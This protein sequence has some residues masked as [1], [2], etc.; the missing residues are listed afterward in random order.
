MNSATPEIDNEVELLIIKI[1]Q[2][3]LQFRRTITMDLLL[4]DVLIIPK[5]DIT[6]IYRANI[7]I[8]DNLI[9]DISPKAQIPDP[10]F[11]ISGKSLVVLP[12]P[13]NGHTHLPMSLL[14]GYSDN[15]TL[16]DWLQNIWEIEGKF[17][18]RWIA[19]GT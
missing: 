9:S 3:T 1:L 7:V 19:L 18:A 11:K 4:Q 15:K 16:M 17:D 5:P 13:I 6:T 12:P 2:N 10:E 14:R 8:E